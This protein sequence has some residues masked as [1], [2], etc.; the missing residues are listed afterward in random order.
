MTEFSNTFK[1]L[2]D[3]PDKGK[4]CSDVLSKYLDKWENRLNFHS[5]MAVKYH[6][7]LSK[8]LDQ[9]ARLQNILS[10]KIISHDFKILAA[11][12]FVKGLESVLQ[13]GARRGEL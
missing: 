12:V 1:R 7:P 11:F 5:K 9:V 4:K 2:L 8:N 13:E 3:A 6:K 10:D